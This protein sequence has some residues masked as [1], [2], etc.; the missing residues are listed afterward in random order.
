MTKEEILSIIDNAY[1]RYEPVVCYVQDCYFSI[2]NRYVQILPTHK[3]IPKDGEEPPLDNLDVNPDY[4]SESAR[5]LY[6]GWPEVMM[7]SMESNAYLCEEGHGYEI[8]LRVRI[9]DKIWVRVIN[10]GPETFR[11]TEWGSYT[12]IV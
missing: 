2:Y 6:S 11:N 10:Y 8:V 7:C 12:E 1:T 4:Q 9:E 3:E 5:S